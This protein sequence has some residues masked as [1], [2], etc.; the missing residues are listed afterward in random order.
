MHSE[1]VYGWRTAEKQHNW[2]SRLPGSELLR[3]HM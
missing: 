1:T 2:P 3:V